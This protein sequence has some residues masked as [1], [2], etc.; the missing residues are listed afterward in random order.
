MFRYSKWKRYETHSVTS[1]YKTGARTYIR[2]EIFD[3]DF[4]AHND[5]WIKQREKSGSDEKHKPIA[6]F[7]V[8]HY[9]LGYHHYY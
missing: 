5:N 3:I 9:Y 7:V 2:N 6:G 1:R 8:L 4:N